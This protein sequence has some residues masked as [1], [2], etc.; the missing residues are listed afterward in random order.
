MGG[1]SACEAEVDRK[2]TFTTIPSITS[3]TVYV[4]PTPFPSD[5][6]TT[7][8]TLIL[9]SDF[10]Q[11][12]DSNSNGKYFEILTPYDQLPSGLNYLYTTASNPAMI[13][14]FNIDQR[15]A[16]DFVLLKKLPP[17]TENMG[18]KLRLIGESTLPTI[19]SFYIKDTEKKNNDGQSVTVYEELS[20]YQYD[21]LNDEFSLLEGKVN[22]EKDTFCTHFE[23]SDDY[24]LVGWSCLLETGQNVLYNLDLNS[25]EGKLL[26]PPEGVCQNND[27][28]K[29]WSSIEWSNDKQWMTA[30]CIDKYREGTP[31]TCLVSSADDKFSCKKPSPGFVSGFSPDGERLVYFKSDQENINTRYIFIT[32]QACMI[33]KEECI[34][35]IHYDLDQLFVSVLWDHGSNELLIS[36]WDPVDDGSGGLTEGI[37]NI[38][39][40]DVGTGEVHS[41]AQGPRGADLVSISPD[42][43]WV[44][45]KRNEVYG[46]FLM[47]RDGRNFLMLEDILGEETNFVGWLYKPEP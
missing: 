18:N 27:L 15:Q 36:Q 24:Q 30:T 38:K 42:G 45:M 31:V 3:A 10:S 11:T 29:S 16:G 40:I 22:R 7:T 34:E 14:Y 5:T 20:S 28:Q 44:Q 37:T 6:P 39:S 19:G 46:Y 21:I 26:V 41:I 32:D 25:G 17:A 4:S 23:F 47:S 2:S 33:S 35:Q 12:K 43:N 8:P 9:I 13:K 1:I